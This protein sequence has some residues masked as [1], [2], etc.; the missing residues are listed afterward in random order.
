MNSQA[1]KGRGRGLGKGKL[2]RDSRRPSPA[3][4]RVTSTG[5]AKGGPAVIVQIVGHVMT[6]EQISNVLLAA[7]WRWQETDVSSPVLTATTMQEIVQH[8]DF[9]MSHVPV[10]IWLSLLVF[11]EQFLVSSA[12]VVKCKTRLFC[13]DSDGTRVNSTFSN[14]AMYT[15]H[16]ADHRERYGFDQGSS[17][18]NSWQHFESVD[19]GHVFST[20]HSMSF[21][22]SGTL[23][24]VGSFCCGRRHALLD[25]GASRSVGDY[26]MVQYMIDC[27]SQN[28]APPWLESANPAASFTFAGGEKAHSETRIWLPLPGTRHERSAVHITSS[29]VTPILLGLDM[30][31]EF[32]LVIDTDSAHC[33]ITKLRCR[34]PVTV[35]PSGHLALALTP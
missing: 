11:V 21:T 29:E 20:V 18:I 16:R 15:S 28:T 7:L 1:S 33:Y 4:S 35:L 22:F 8:T 25:T 10:V 14:T 3:K 26:M 2:P 19:D 24:R 30:L 6:L 17:L 23:C 32:G 31:R 27:L 13:W 5:T 9:N 12:C 34:I